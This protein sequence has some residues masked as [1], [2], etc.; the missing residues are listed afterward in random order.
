MNRKAESISLWKSTTNNIVLADAIL[1]VSNADMEIAISSK[2]PQF[3][4]L[5]SI[6]CEELLAKQQINFDE[7]ENFSPERYLNFL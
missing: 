7:F 2:F 5:C 6:L 1:T 3:E 4:N